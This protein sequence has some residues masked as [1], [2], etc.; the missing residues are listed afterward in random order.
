MATVADGVELVSWPWVR[1]AA[2]SGSAS[3]AGLGM[4][5]L[6]YDHHWACIPVFG[7]FVTLAVLAMRALE[8]ASGK[9]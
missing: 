1:L 4:L 7:A 3:S 6:A 5:V 2:F 8:V 9:E